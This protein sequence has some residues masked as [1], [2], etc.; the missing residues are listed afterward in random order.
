M[1]DNRRF[2]IDGAWVAP[3]TASDCPV[4]NP[5]TGEPI[6][7]ISLGSAADV[8]RAVTAARRAF[9]DY[10]TSTIPER[11]ALIDRVIAAYQRRQDDIAHAISDEMGAPLAF[12]RRSQAALGLGHLK[13]IRE[14]LETFPFTEDREGLRLIRE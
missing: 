1:Y 5:A 10:S 3:A 11:M 14:V 6:G 7:T 9:A 4:I 13:T 2:Y 12:A 8:D